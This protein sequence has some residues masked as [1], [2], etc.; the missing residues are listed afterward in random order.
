MNTAG[1]D[2]GMVMVRLALGPMLVVHGWNKA[3]GLGGLTGTTGWF[4]SM[5]FRPAR[6]HARIGAASEI[7][8]GI[9]LILGFLTGLTCAAFVALMVVAAV[10]GHRGK[11]YFVFNG[12]V[13]YV[14]LVAMTAVGAA[15][16]G[17][18]EWSLDH[19]VGWTV[20]GPWWALAAGVGGAL[21]G[22][23]FVAVSCRPASE[24]VV[25]QGEGERI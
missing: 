21:A 17:P 22:R 4:E 2:I 8:A 13:E 18:G 5:G 19:A 3:F 1:L 14:V 16:A 23:T 6:L 24:A 20:A 7:C 25:S 15:A 10:T 12:G 9:L 11:G